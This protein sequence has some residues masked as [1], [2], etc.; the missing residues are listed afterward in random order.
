MTKRLMA[1][2]SDNLATEICRILDIEVG[3]IARMILDL[4]AGQPIKVYVDAYADKAIEDIDW[5]RFLAGAEVKKPD[6]IIEDL[7][8]SYWTGLKTDYGATTAT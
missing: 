2:L 4:Q 7:E 3:T 5:A 1:A 6:P 8:A